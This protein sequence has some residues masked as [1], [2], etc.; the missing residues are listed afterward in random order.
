MRPKLH[1]PG[2]YGP[3][4]RRKGRDKERE[5]MKKM[6]QEQPGIYLQGH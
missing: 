6:M 2:L 3:K 5:R 1:P 4:T